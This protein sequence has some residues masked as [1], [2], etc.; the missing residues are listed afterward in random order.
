MKNFLSSAIIFA[1]LL[2]VGLAC[3]NSAARLNQSKCSV[4]LPELDS[5]KNYVERGTAE[6]T[7]GNY[8]CAFDDCQAALR[9]DPKNVVALNCRGEVHRKRERFDSAQADFDEALKLEPDNYQTFYFR[10]RLYQAT[11]SFQ[12]ALAD[13]NEA[14]RLAPEHYYFAARAELLFEM[15]NYEE[16]LKD[17]TEAIRLRPEI[18]DYYADRARVYRRAKQP[19]LAQADELRARRIEL[20]DKYSLDAN[21]REAVGEVLNEKAVSLPKPPYPRLA[22]SVK[23]GG[24]V[25]VQI[26]VD[27]KGNVTSAKTIAGHPLLHAVSEG[28]ALRA[29]FKPAAM[30]G[31]LIYEFDV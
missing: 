5:A 24:A 1:A 15:G 26:Q 17:Y 22:Q 3:K 23:A 28:A 21:Q 19:E 14:V 29:K 31:I 4:N 9:L 7:A 16:A 2:G 18:R 11:K 25:T 6:I 8:D 30:S 27:A 10:S 20:D 12:P 13:M